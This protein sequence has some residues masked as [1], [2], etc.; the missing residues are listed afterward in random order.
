MLPRSN[1]NPWVA[2][3]KWLTQA[4]I[5]S[6]TLNIGFI[7]TFVYFVLKDKQET[8][9]VEH[10]PLMSGS[11]EAHPTNAQLIRS[12][13][14]L[15]FQELILRLE[16]KDHI[17]EGLRKRDLALACLVAFHHFNLDKALGNLNLQKRVIPLINNDEQEA[18]DIPVFP[19]LADQQ[20]QAILNFAKT[21][22]WPI[23]SQGLFYELKRLSP[24]YD[25]S[26]LEAFYLTS[27]YHATHTLLSKTGVD[28]SGE[29]L[30]DLIVEGEWKTLSEISLWQCSLAD[31][32]PEHRR[33]LLIEYFNCRSKIAARLLLD[34]DSEF[35]IKRFDDAQILTLLDLYPEK[36]LPIE[37]FAKGLLLSP[38]SD[39]VWKRAAAILYASISEPL[40]EPYDHS[41][42]L[43]RFLPQDDVLKP[44]EQSQPLIIPTAAPIA[45]ALTTKKII[46]TIEVGDSLWKIA[47]KYHVTIEEIKRLNRMETEKLLPGKKLEIP[48]NPKK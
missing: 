19:G 25:A 20:F 15:P 48:E 42:A 18:I 21:E 36:T 4:L 32:Q 34:F 24:N 43:R 31:L 33:H 47:R 23:T 26:L 41:L 17:E 1:T 27:E 29:Q 9:T 6:G 30:V 16:N 35:V 3:T 44:K 8:F 22:K 38:R 40:P 45:S 2:R 28:L 13:S 12:Y 11:K 14:V 39:S 5:I 37:K 10:A 46:H 7:A